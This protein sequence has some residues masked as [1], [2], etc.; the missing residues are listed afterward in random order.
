[1]IQRAK[2]N[3][4]RQED[5]DLLIY[6]VKQSI[7]WIVNSQNTILVRMDVWQVMNLWNF[8]RE[9]HPSYFRDVALDHRSTGVYSGEIY[10]LTRS[11]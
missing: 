1:M 3:F 4:I 7:L 9:A 10:F 8:E 6:S 5:T 11:E 2:V